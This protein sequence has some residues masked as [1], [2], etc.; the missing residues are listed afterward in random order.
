MDAI[1]LACFAM[2]KDSYIP[3]D[4]DFLPSKKESAENLLIKKDLFSKL[5]DEAKQVIHIVLNSSQELI[6][7]K[8]KLRKF[9]Y[10]SGVPYRKCSQIFKE[11]NSFLKE[12]EE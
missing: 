7:N 1:E 5:S 9:L 10:E 11:I 4:E 6:P 8:S 12:I 2:R 3:Y